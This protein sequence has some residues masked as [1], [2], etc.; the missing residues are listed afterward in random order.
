LNKPCTA[1]LVFHVDGVQIG[2]SPSI[3]LCVFL[4]FPKHHLGFT[5]LAKIVETK[6]LKVLHNVNTRWINMLAFLKRVRKDY[7]TLFAK[8][9]VNSGIV[10][11]PR[12][13]S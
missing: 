5:K 9:V 11:E 10:E 12:L 4:Q 6:G 2:E 3:I 7:K 8:M 1:K 13:M